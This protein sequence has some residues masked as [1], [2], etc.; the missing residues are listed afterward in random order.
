MAHFLDNIHSEDIGYFEK[1]LV[2]ELI[3]P[4][5]WVHD[6]LRCELPVGF[7]SDG[8]S[9]PRVPFIYDAWGDKCHRE[10]FTHDFGYRKDSYIIVV[11][12]VEINMWCDGLM[13]EEYIIERR[14][15]KKEDADWLLFRQSIKDHIS[16]NPK[17]GEITTTYSYATYQPMYLAVR[18]CGGSSFHRMNVMDKFEVCQ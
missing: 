6:N 17:T 11:K 7:Q 8:A 4:L 12:S 14:P 18:T 10:A 9:V 15:I 1:R 2:R 16:T 5:I 13:P 3:E